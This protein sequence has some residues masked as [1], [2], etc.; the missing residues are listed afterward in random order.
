MNL[1]RTASWRRAVVLSV[2]L[3]TAAVPERLKQDLADFRLNLIFVGRQDW[4]DPY[5]SLALRV[6][7]IRPDRPP[8]PV[9]PIVMVSQAQARKI[10][11]E[12][13]RRGL[14]EG[15]GE[16]S[17]STRVIP[18]AAYL[19]RVR[20]MHEHLKSLC[21][22]LTGE[23]GTVMGR[24]VKRLA[25]GRQAP[26]A[27][28]LDDADPVMR[29]VAV[30]RLAERGR[31]AVGALGEALGDRDQ[32]VRRLAAVALGGIGGPAKSA[33]PA[34]VQLLDDP[35]RDVW[36]T[37]AEAVG[38]IGRDGGGGVD[39]LVKALKDGDAK[40]R[41]RAAYVLR[42][43]GPPAYRAR[44]AL[45]EAA[46]DK[47][48]HVRRVVAGALKWIGTDPILPPLILEQHL[49]IT[50]VMKAVA[51]ELARI[52]PKYPQLAAYRKDKALRRTE[53]HVSVSY[54]RNFTWP[55]VKRGIVP[56]DFGKDGIYVTFSC[57]SNLIAYPMSW[58]GSTLR[59]LRLYVWTDVWAGT[60]ASADLVKDVRAILRRGVR[61]LEESDRAA[62]RRS[63]LRHGLAEPDAATPVSIRL[64]EMGSRP[65]PLGPG[66]RGIV[67][68]MLGRP[69]DRVFHEM[70][71]TAM[72]YPRLHVGGVK[73]EWYGSIVS[74]T[75][76]PWPYYWKNWTC[77]RLAPLFHRMIKV[78][79]LTDEKLA[80]ILK[81][82]EH[83]LKEQTK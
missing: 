13:A 81:Q 47:D 48:K 18:S 70:P 2:L 29:L 25:P 19:L 83:D 27:H 53:S 12:L 55:T 52:A 30:R 26:V 43:I 32:A 10:V 82:F 31:Q 9:R 56:S 64:S 78:R 16:P 59:A 72:T 23:A 20:R 61:K 37:A 54:V 68:A 66:A 42:D 22:V 80:A 4:S 75:H 57:A 49:A 11:D 38:D 6:P 41:F 79:D 69:A 8:P 51:E 63:K 33:L 5:R 71:L 24:L 15:P 36:R 60:D 67:L 58:P 74:Y 14:L 7:P 62:A 73:Y 50:P 44:A 34:L 1:E 76:G 46:K 39:V 40:R 21:G 28:R 17:D 65:V 45:R 35:D 3:P 77:W